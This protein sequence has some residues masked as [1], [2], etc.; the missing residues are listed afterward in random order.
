MVKRLWMARSVGAALACCLL[1][2]GPAS[3]GVDELKAAAKRPPSEPDK[4]LELGRSLRQ[5]GLYD[6]ALRVLRKG[7]ARASQGDIGVSLR[8][9]A[10]RSLIAANKQK[11]AVAECRTLKPLSAAKAEACHAEAQL[12]WKR[13]SLALPAADA[14]LEKSP[15]DYDALVAKGRAL[16]QMGNLQEGEQALRQA[17]AADGSRYEAELWLG[18]LLR[19]AGRGAD[20][21]KAFRRAHQL[22]P[23][24]PEPL[25]ELARALAPGAEAESSLQ[26][27]LAIRPDFG[28]ALAAL[29]DVSLELGKL[30]EAEKA[31]KRAV[32]ISPKEAD[33]RASLAR[34][35]LAKGDHDQAL[36]ESAV[37][38]KIV[39]N[40]GPAKLVEADA[41]AKRGDIDLAIVAYEKAFGLMR[42]DPKPLVH[43]ARSTLDGGRPTTARAFA[44]RAT[45]QFPSWAPAWEVLGDVSV[46]N[47]DH[48]GAR[49][50]Y[51]KALAGK[52]RVDKAKIKQ[53]LAKL[54]KS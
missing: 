43:A 1:G 13:A 26:K 8:L 11:P 25:L 17:I 20:A 2:T 36:K 47:G 14:A 18:D 24:E 19:A 50:A 27:A 40:H 28:A 46:Q 29:G 49:R 16:R 4:I 44:E 10:A 31:L 22:A 12:L 32:A 23:G 38:L 30:D 52:G 33:W 48:K 34:L 37:A 5:A 42:T 15:G 9:E 3:A 6:D 53:K 45:Q 39:S 41:L 21:I 54:P 35:R 7:Y 51:D